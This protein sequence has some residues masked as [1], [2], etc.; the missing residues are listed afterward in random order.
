MSFS[1]SLLSFFICFLI[2]LLILKTPFFDFLKHRKNRFESLDGLRGFLALSV[3]FHHFVTAY[4][5]KANDEWL[6]PPETY[7]ANYG[8]VGVALFFMITGFLFTAKLINDQG[9]TNWFRLYESRFFRI[10]P[11]YIFAIIVISMIVFHQSNYQL[12]VSPIK[13]LEEYVKWGVFHG[14]AINNFEDTRTIIAKVDWTLK[15]ESLFYVVLPLLSLVFYRLGRLGVFL[16]IA[17]SIF[18]YIKPLD[19]LSFSTLY[20]ILF[21]VGGI[22]AFVK[23][24]LTVPEHFIQ[25]P[26]VSSIVLALLGACVFFPYYMGWVHVIMMSILFLLITLGNHI[27]GLLHTTPAKLLGEISYSIYLLHGIVIYCAVSEFG[28]ID[29][30]SLEPTGYMLLMPMLSIIVVGLSALT[31]IFI[32]KPFMTLGKQYILSNKLNKLL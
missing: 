4:Y 19:I 32:E 21:C 22:I 10:F 11:L 13:L 5:W 31:F 24:K 14:Q 1:I 18:L 12:N 2:A 15:Y 29:I 26:W 23:S 20:F 3:F 27:Y 25:S 7:Y 8:F 17:G 9:K 6:L 16:L 30:P 28:F